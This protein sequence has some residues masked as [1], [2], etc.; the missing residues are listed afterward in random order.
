MRECNRWTTASRNPGGKISS[1][2]VSELQQGSF[3]VVFTVSEGQS[4]EAQVNGRF[5][6]EQVNLTEFQVG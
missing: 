5:E 6:V 4:D 1:M 2:I 3:Y